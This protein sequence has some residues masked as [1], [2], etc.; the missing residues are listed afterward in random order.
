MKND[1][2][3]LKRHL[4][5]ILIYSAIF[6][7]ISLVFSN[8][9]EEAVLEIRYDNY[10]KAINIL[11]K[12][13][14][15]DKENPDAYFYL[16]LAYEQKNQYDDAL[17]IM[18]KGLNYVQ[19]EL[20]KGELYFNLGNNYYKKMDYNSALNMYSQAIVLN[21]A[22]NGVY[23]HKG[24]SFYKLK[25]YE[26]TVEQWELYLEK[27]PDTP[28][29]ENII[30][31]IAFLKNIL[32]REKEKKALEEKQRKELLDDLLNQIDSISKDSKGVRVKEKNIKESPDIFELE[33]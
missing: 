7:H 24:Q 12:L 10:D 22:I 3:F 19:D 27:K 17:L 25:N 21:P 29:H 32:A 5:I 9:L 14:A 16:G 11:Q 30:N 4:K 20:K 31:A 6:I 18:K 23:L 2:S 8:D 1:F 13:L 26:K 15:Y 28:Q 33:K